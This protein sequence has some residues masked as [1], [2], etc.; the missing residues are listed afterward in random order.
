MNEDIG[1]G[2]IGIPIHE[3]PESSSQVLVFF[4]GSC[5]STQCVDLAN[6]VKFPM[7][8]IKEITKQGFPITIQ[9]KKID[10]VSVKAGHGIEEGDFLVVRGKSYEIIA[11][12]NDDAAHAIPYARNIIRVSRDFENNCRNQPLRFK[13]DPSCLD[14]SSV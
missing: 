13:K 2:D 8:S 1:R 4:P 9:G 3:N 5:D 12:T 6:L 10:Y 7:N 14:V 11:V